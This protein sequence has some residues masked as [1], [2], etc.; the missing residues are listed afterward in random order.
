VIP[1]KTVHIAQRTVLTV[2]AFTWTH[3]NR[4]YLSACGAVTY[5]LE[6]AATTYLAFVPATRVL[7]LY[8]WLNTDQRTATSRTVTAYPA[9]FQS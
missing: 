7:T 1:N 2:T 6:G 8:S 5:Q 3:P 4:N 9:N